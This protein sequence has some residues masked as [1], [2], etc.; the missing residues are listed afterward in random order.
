MEINFTES[1]IEKM[2]DKVRQTNETQDIF[3]WN[4]DG[5]DINI[6]VGDDK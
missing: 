6:T 1:D 5:I 4:V 2:L 3:I